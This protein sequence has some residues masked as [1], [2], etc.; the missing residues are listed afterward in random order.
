[1]LS[2][3]R[4]IGS[5]QNGYRNTYRK[6]DVVPCR[7]ADPSR[8]ISPKS[9]LLTLYRPSCH[10]SWRPTECSNFEFESLVC[11]DLRKTMIIF[12]FVFLRPMLLNRFWTNVSRFREL[13]F[14]L[15][16]QLNYQSKGRDRPLTP[17][18]AVYMLF[19]L[20]VIYNIYSGYFFFSIIRVLFEYR[21][22]RII[23]HCSNLL[24]ALQA[25]TYRLI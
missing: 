6:R 2:I 12:V 13:L 15:I 23:P 17:R 18:N 5:K 11:L 14:T 1:M 21:S 4:V 19:N 20:F 16:F 10:F 22:G 8:S 9:Q 24:Q 3:N 25:F 7:P